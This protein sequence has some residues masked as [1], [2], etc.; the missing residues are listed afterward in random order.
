VASDHSYALTGDCNVPTPESEDEVVEFKTV[1]TS[2]ISS[3]PTGTGSYQH[4]N[5][6]KFSTKVP[7]T[8]SSSLHPGQKRINIDVATFSKF[9]DSASSSHSRKNQST[10]RS[11]QGN[12]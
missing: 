3:R 1:E 8:S 6:L 4:V 9:L 7:T 11:I 2:S 5:K 10:T 12:V